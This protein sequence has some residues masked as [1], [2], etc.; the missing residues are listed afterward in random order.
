LEEGLD[1]SIRGLQL[2]V[3]ADRIDRLENGKLVVIDYKTGRHFMSEWF[4]DRPVEPQVP[5][6]SLFCPEPVAGVYFGVVRKGE[7]CFVGLGEDADIVPGCKA[8]AQHSLTRDFP[9][10]TELLQHWKTQLEDLAA[11][12]LRGE[13]R[14][15]PSTKQACRQ[16]DLHA[17]CRIYEL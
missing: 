14:V 8:F 15:A 3:V 17:L 2:N 12:V 4:Q 11:E 7:S 1:I 6:Y 10:W 13:A 16:C 5:L 9:S